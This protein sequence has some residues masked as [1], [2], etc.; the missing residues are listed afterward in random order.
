[1]NPTI[2]PSQLSYEQLLELVRQLIAENGRLR[3]DNAHL[4]AEIEQLKRKNARS[5]APFSK[6]ERKKD[7]KRSGRKPGQGEFRNRSGPPEED[8]SGPPVEVPVTETVCPEC[9]GDLIEAGEEIVTTTEIPPAPQPEVKAYRIRIRTCCKCPRKVRG[10]H[11]EVAPDQ[12]GATAHRVGPRAQAAAHLLH[13]GEGIPQRKVP[14]VL[15][16]LTGLPVTQGALTQSALRLGTGQGAVAQAYEHL[17]EEIKEQEAVHTDDTGWRVGGQ[18]AQLMVFESKSITLYQIRARHR[19]E[20]VRE[21]IGDHYQGTLCTDRG[22]S[23]DAKEL[24]ETKQQK[25][26]SH[27]LRSIDEVLEAKR[28]P[29]RLFGEV[30][31]SQLQAAIGLYHAFHDPE[32]KGRDYDERVRAMEWEV[33]H[34]LR[35]RA[36]KDRDNQRL[37]NELGRHHEQGNL[38]RFLHD[39][40][41]IEPTNNAAERALRP[42]VIARKVSQCSKNERGAAAS[43]A[44]RSVIGTLKKRGGDVLEKLTRLIGLSPPPETLSAT[45]A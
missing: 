8:Y 41:A 29:A 10:Q 45:P 38:L 2:D 34:H 13:Y 1:M 43:S 15:K 35:P 21:V 3:A 4:R 27:I 26:L 5:A 36:L 17:R 19:N 28:G 39:P 44:F 32:K 7:P 22:K 6:G 23:Y 37:L 40:T 16:S 31:K 11:P 14:R 9:G 12:S 18:A 42:A 25:C 30:L 33:S 20:E 24:A